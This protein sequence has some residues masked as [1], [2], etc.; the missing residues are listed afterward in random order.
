MRV[1]FLVVLAA[2]LLASCTHTATLTRADGSITIVEGTNETDVIAAANAI[3][4]VETGQFAPDQKSPYTRTRVDI[5]QDNRYQKVRPATGYTYGER[6]TIEVRGKN[7]ECVQKIWFDGHISYSVKL[8]KRN[9][10]SWEKL[11]TALAVRK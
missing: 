5:R 8:D 9:Y 4:A 7:V 10:P 11:E 3:V 1:L 2:I 6:K